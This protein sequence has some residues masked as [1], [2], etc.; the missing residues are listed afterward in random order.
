MRHSDVLLMLGDFAVNHARDR[1][2]NA[3]RN[4]DIITWNAPEIKLILLVNSVRFKNLFT[5]CFANNS[6]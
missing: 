2:P 4:A 1:G 6:A 5:L 3:T